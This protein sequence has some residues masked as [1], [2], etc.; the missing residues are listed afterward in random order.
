MVLM[1]TYLFPTITGP[2]TRV[3]VTKA[4]F[5]APV[6]K[7]GSAAGFAE[8]GFVPAATTTTGAVG[9]GEGATGSIPTT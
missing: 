9:S 4:C 8:A 5:V 1:N 3:I 2:K 7:A 6:A